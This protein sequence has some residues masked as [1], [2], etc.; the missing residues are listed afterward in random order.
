[1]TAE[2]SR[3]HS[4]GAHVPKSK[5]HIYSLYPRF[6]FRIGSHTANQELIF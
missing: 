1:M 6:E 2:V 5:D 3:S 4:D